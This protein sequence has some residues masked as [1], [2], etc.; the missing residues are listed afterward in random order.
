[1][2]I[3]SW[4]ERVPAD[5][6]WLF[7]FFS[8]FIENIFPPYPGD[9]VTVLGGYLV[10]KGKL[11]LLV[12]ANSVFAGS[13][14]GALIM[15]YFGQKVIVFL[16][17][18]FKIQFI[19]KEFEEEKFTKTQQWFK[20]NGF[21][22]IIFSRFSA[23]IRFF[24]SIVAGV[25]RMNIF[26]FVLAFSLATIIWNTLLIWGG[27]SLGENWSEILEYLKLYNKIVITMI[28]LGILL[29]L[30]YRRKNRKFVSTK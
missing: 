29:F 9:S 16:T 21:V 12:M 11:S 23:G 15:Y 8:S 6:Y 25:T 3:E 19:A 17:R 27:Y 24:T 22:T 2:D 7:I 26:V 5:L 20:R 1:M 30:I 10:S 28:I 13:M 18:T 14:L 4:L